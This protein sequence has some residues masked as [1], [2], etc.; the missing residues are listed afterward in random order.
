MSGISGR[1]NMC[2]PWG[3]MG[4]LR[5]IYMDACHSDIQHSDYMDRNKKKSCD[6]RRDALIQDN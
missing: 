6:R 3:E 2:G 1:R 4:E 5:Q